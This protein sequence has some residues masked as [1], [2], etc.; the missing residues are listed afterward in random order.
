MGDDDEFI[1][2]PGVGREHWGTS[3]R[4]YHGADAAYD[5]FKLKSQSRQEQELRDEEAI[6]IQ[7]QKDQMANQRQ[8]DFVDLEMQAMMEQELKN[9]QQQTKLA[10]KIKKKQ[11]KKQRMLEK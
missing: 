9:E 5:D 11:N 1:A 3:K 10:R 8:N 2:E 7:M 6:G 4:N